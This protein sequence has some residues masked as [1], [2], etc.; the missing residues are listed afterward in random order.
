LAQGETSAALAVLEPVR[1]QAEARGLEDERLKV[2]VLQAVA[3]FAHGEKDKAAQLLGDALR[4]AEP[5]GF[6]RLFVDEGP[7][8]AALL[9]EV[10]KR[11]IAPN[12]V[13]QLR[14]AFAKAEG[15][16]TTTQ[17]LIE[18]LSEREL[19]VLR[20]L[21]SESNG[22]EI[23]RALMV[24]LNTMRTHTKNIYGKLGVSSRRAAVRRA[25]ELDLLKRTR[26]Q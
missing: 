15:G 25:E 9:R 1:R 19:E 4:L 17:L 26:K 16:I 5:G 10:A 13:C 12:Y 7:P 2:M 24:S 14:A 23:A 8:M 20:L 3:L 21:G 6:I 18:P 11:G 22:P